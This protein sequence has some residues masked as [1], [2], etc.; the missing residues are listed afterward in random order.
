MQTK[1]FESWTILPAV[2]VMS[3]AVLGQV[4]LG[5]GWTYQGRLLE[6]GAPVNDSVD[7]RFTLCES[8]AAGC[9]LGTTVVFDGQL[10]NDPPVDIID[11]LITVE[12]DFGVAA[13]DGNARW[14]RVEV[15][16]P[17]DPSDAA[18]Y[19]V[20][21]PRQLLTT[22]PYALYALNAPTGST[23]WGSNGANLYYDAGSVGIGTDSPLAPLHVEG[24]ARA[25][26][27]SVPNPD[28][29][30]A[31]A[32]L[33][34]H[35]NVPRIRYGGSGPGNH[36]GFAIHGIGDS[37]K[38]RLLD[39]GALGLGTSAPGSVFNSKLDVIGGHVAVSNNYGFFSFNG[40]NDGIGAGVD[41][42]VS[43]ELHL[44]AAGAPR[45]SVT[46][47]G[48]VGIG[49]TSPAARLDVR[50]S[51]VLDDGARAQLFTAASG[52][53][54]SRH[55]LLL[56]SPDLASASGLKAG[57]VLVADNYGYA[58]PGKNDLIVKGDVGV[59]TASPQATLHVVSDAFPNVRVT[60]TDNTDFAR[61]M[62][63]GNGSTVQLNVGSPGSSSPHTF[64]I[65]RPG[66][67][68]MVSIPQ[69]GY[70]GIGTSTPDATLHVASDALPNV[71]I[72]QT[73]DTDFARLSLE[74]GGN[75]YQLSA[76]GPSSSLPGVFNIYRAGSGNVFSITPAANVGI[77]TNFPSSKLHV[78]GRTTTEEIDITG[79]SDLSERFDI[80]GAAV[81]PGM[82]VC[83]DPSS[84]GKLVVSNSEYDPTVAGV[85][86]GA[87][88][89]DPGMLMGQKGTVADG[90]HPVALTGRV[91][92]RA[93]TANGP[94]RPG[95][96]LTTSAI[97]GYAMKATDRERAFGATIG[98]AMTGLDVGEGEGIGGGNR[99]GLV[100]VLVSLQ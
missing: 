16:S 40:S 77:G 80:N 98:K 69:N 25:A 62:L 92:V 14:L 2:L 100:L 19:E 12:L 9:T 27:F 72:T 50:G 44:Y 39:N 51:M 81:R 91:Y 34:W 76:G 24:V 84:P 33:S 43:D 88:G 93:T 17:H 23:P 35:N 90:T 97:P 4:P 57:G 38:L 45:A 71:Q 89:V 21:S 37:V 30:S 18:P 6:S 66:V 83:I 59:G 28:N 11:G 7:L 8:E 32:T 58:D 52:G 31:S 36:N 85:V 87:G 94:V 10:G 64:N 41:T 79:G 15:R 5:T 95:D 74:A 60:Q 53:D 29:M 67:G 78:N 1:R 20:L 42:T 61:L 82:V 75:E 99:E 46:A 65:Y 54:Q 96:M 73:D 49:T 86:S 48:D 26:S 70:V 22:A 56:N 63:D 55:L 47:G 13:F 3:G 68:N